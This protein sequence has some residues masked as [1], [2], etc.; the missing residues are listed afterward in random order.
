MKSS[1]YV[2]ICACKY[3]ILL[4]PWFS[5][6]L[7]M[8][9]VRKPLKTVFKKIDKQNLGSSESNNPSFFLGLTLNSIF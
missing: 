1:I 2:H 7:L 4:V 9:H 6:C 5:R 8:T 3:N